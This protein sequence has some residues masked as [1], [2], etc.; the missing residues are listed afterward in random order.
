MKFNIYVDSKIVIW[1]RQYIEVEA[2][3]KDEIVTKVLNNNFKC[4]E[5]EYLM[6]TEDPIQSSLNR[7][8]LEI[9]CDEFGYEP[10]YTNSK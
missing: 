4:D 10:L 8:T 1:K 5:I 9:Y 3:S 6:E 7:P 2:K